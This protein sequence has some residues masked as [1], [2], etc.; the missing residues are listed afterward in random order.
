MT[1]PDDPPVLTGSGLARPPGR[2]YLRPTPPTPMTQSPALARLPL[3]D[4]LRRDEAAVAT[5]VVGIVAF[6]ALAA[7]G[8]QARIYLWEVP[9]TLQTAAVYGAGLFL[10]ARNGALSMGL[11]L[12]AGLVLPVFASGAHGLEYL[13]GAT[14]GYLLAYPLAALLVGRLTDRR[15]GFVASALA[16]TAGL[17]LVFAAGVVWLHVAAGH[18]TWWESIVKG[19]LLFVVWDVAKVW[20]VAGGYLGARKAAGA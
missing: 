10:G 17:A 12:A 6:A 8:A 1:R 20:L 13:T 4:L 3:S 15:R 19:A 9:I 5:Q 11:Y 2:L 16:M 18:A 14:G 7:L